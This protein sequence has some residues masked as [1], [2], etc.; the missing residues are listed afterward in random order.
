MGNRKVNLLK[1]AEIEP[2]NAEITSLGIGAVTITPEIAF[3]YGLPSDTRGVIATETEGLA[4]SCGIRDG[5]IIG[6]VNNRPTPDL[7]SFLEAIKKGD[8]SKG[9]IFSLIRRGRPMEIVMEEKPQLL[10]RGL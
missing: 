7:I 1:N 4:L 6:K 9:I 5:D 10:P 3:T 8:L 2:G